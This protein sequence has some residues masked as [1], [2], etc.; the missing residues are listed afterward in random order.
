[1]KKLKS[2]VQ[3]SQNY[4]DWPNYVIRVTTRCHFEMARLKYLGVLAGSYV[5][6]HRFTSLDTTWRKELVS[7]MTAGRGEIWF[8]KIPKYIKKY[9]EFFCNLTLQDYSFQQYRPSMLAAGAIMASRVA[10]QV[11]PRWRPE[12]TRLTGYDEPD[13]VEVFNHIWSYYG[14]QFPDHGSRAISPRSVTT[15]LH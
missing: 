5:H 9:A 14:E 2:I 6:F 11:E 15:P 1:M 7:S 8:P 12:L 13:I 3:I 4:S 10:L